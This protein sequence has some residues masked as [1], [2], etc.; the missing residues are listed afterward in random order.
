MRLTAGVESPRAQI[1]QMIESARARVG[2]VFLVKTMESIQLFQNTLYL[3]V[4]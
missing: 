3:F 2:F 4:I 1:L